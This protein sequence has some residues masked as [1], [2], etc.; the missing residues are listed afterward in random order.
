MRIPYFLSVVF[1]VVCVQTLSAQRY[2]TKTGR[3]TFTSQ[4]P[5]EKIESSNNNSLIVLDAATGKLECSVLIKGFQF[6]KA[7]MQEHFNEN[8][9]ESHKYPKGLFKGTVTN[10]KDIRLDKDG[11]YTANLKGDLTLH[12]VT[13]PLTT[14]GKITV[15]GGNVA[16]TTSFEVVVADFNIEIPKV[17]KDNIAEKVKVAVSADLQL[18]DETN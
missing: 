7:L 11:V 5:L 14:S 1:L 18:M 15:K 13:K 9:M 10:M 2:Y 6:T 4:A 16:A 12:G 17:V 8:Y 3:I